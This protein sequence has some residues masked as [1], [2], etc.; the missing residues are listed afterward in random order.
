MNYCWSLSRPFHSI[1]INCTHFPINHNEIN[2]ISVIV[3]GQENYFPCKRTKNMGDYGYIS[4]HH[5][6]LST[7]GK[8]NHLLLAATGVHA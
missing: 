4:D 1:F 7:I 8:K 5:N 6:V 3:Y 2:S